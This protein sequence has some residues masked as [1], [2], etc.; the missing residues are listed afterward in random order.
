LGLKFEVLN[1]EVSSLAEVSAKE[2]FSL[3]SGIYS[4]SSKGYTIYCK[5]GFLWSYI[6]QFS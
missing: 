4:F 2:G 5:L 3:P 1:R 6:S